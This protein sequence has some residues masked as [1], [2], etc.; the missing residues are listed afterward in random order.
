MGLIKEL[1]DG[2]Q[3]VLLY[4]KN[5]EWKDETHSGLTNGE[6]YTGRVYRAL[7]DGKN[8]VYYVNIDR[9]Q[10]L[11]KKIKINGVR[12]SKLV[13]ST[14]EWDCEF[15]EIND[16]N[17]LDLEIN[18]EDYKRI[19]E[20]VEDD[21]KDF[22]AI[23]RGSEGGVD[24]VAAKEDELNEDNPSIIETDMESITDHIMRAVRG[25]IDPYVE[26]IDDSLDYLISTD[27]M[28]V[29]GLAFV[30]NNLAEK[31]KNEAKTKVA[32]PLSR[33]IA[34]SDDMGKGANM[35]SALYSIE[36][37]INTDRPSKIHDA[38]Y[39]LITELIRQNINDNNA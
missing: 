28:I 31:V 12:I 13:Y 14:P 11:D 10:D 21:H 3:V 33:E 23:L 30:L 39:H 22:L 6:P 16:E 25:N 7:K 38:I 26:T 19:N 1:K 20:W 36:E 15:I 18:P 35:Y 29:Q 27:P 4:A 32:I 5:F 24:V 2:N 8:D 9:T 37:Y 34:L 17:I